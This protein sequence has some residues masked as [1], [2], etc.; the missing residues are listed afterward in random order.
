MNR[1]I[2][3]VLQGISLLVGIATLTFLL[4]NIIP[5]D[6]ARIMLGP[7]AS[8]ESVQLLRTELGTDRPLWEQYKLHLSKLLELNLG[9]SIIDERV[10]SGEIADKFTTTLKVGLSGLTIALIISYALN[11][12]VFYVPAASSLLIITRFGVV[13]PTFFSG[14]TAAL[15]FG[16]FL[17]VVPLSGYGS[18]EST[19][20]TL[21]LP[22]F[23]T[24]LYPIAVMTGILREKIQEALNSLY[25]HSAFSLGFSRFHIF[26]AVILRTVAVSWL[27]GWVNLLSIVFVATLIVEVIFSIP[28]VGPLLVKSIQQKDYPMLQ[29]IVIVNACFF[30]SL[31]WISEA[32]FRILDPRIRQHA[33]T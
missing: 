16:V 13:T 29:G 2:A 27:A 11:L 26:H 19:I 32:L 8:E 5:G 17:P 4:F 21:A 1:A 20:F 9:R 24:G 12:L 7:N 3:S 31:S 33:E 14:V 25:V 28:G 15:I 22:A 10:V 6:P 18:S 30:I 23:V